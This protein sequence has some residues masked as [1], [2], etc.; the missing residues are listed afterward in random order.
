MDGTIWLLI[1][2]GVLI[3]VLGIVA[4]WV[5]RGKKHEPDYRTFFIMGIIWLAVGIPLENSAL[6]IM[7]LVFMA[8]GLANKNKWKKK[9]KDWSKMN[10]KERKIMI[11][12]IALG[13]VLLILGMI[14]FLLVQK[15]LI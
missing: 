5:N 4:I 11:L 14:A 6:F 1:A 10:K 3:I 7:G 15:G 8:V 12:L 2:I 9:H 13:A